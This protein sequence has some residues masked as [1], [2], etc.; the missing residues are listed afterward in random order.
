MVLQVLAFPC[1][2]STMMIIN[3]DTNSINSRPIS[4]DEKRAVRNNP[5]L[6]E[7]VADPDLIPWGPQS[8]P[9]GER[10]DGLLGE[11]ALASR[12]IIK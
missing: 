2:V 12:Y 11:S 4:E 5:A 6:V 10:D 9:P 7:T 1:I 3:V 8:A